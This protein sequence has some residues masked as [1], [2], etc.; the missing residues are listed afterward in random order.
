MR[1]G[2]RREGDRGGACRRVPDHRQGEARGHGGRAVAETQLQ[3]GD[4]LRLAR[5]ERL[6]R[7]VV[8]RVAP[9]PAGK[10]Y[11]LDRFWKTEIQGLILVL[12]R[13]RRKRRRR[14]RRRR[15]AEGRR[16][17]KKR[18]MKDNALQ[19]RESLRTDEKSS[20]KQ[21]ITEVASMSGGQDILYAI[22]YYTVSV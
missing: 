12:F 22:L 3:V 1:G 2:G 7:G 16:K 11:F 21:D 9:V 14:R 17:W 13:E 4:H 10:S 6:D 5:L 15:A 19:E 18:S 8:C 20:S